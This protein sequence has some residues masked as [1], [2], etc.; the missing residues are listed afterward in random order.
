MGALC[1]HVGEIDEEITVPELVK[2]GSLLSAPGLCIS[3]SQ[4]REEEETTRSVF[5]AEEG[6]FEKSIL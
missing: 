2:E 3:L 5:Y 1:S 4:R 6:I